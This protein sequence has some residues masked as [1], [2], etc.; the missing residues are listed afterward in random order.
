M[1][2]KSENCYSAELQVIKMNDF[3]EAQVKI[4]NVTEVIKATV[5]K[6]TRKEARALLREARKL[7][8]EVRVAADQAGLTEIQI[9]NV[10]NAGS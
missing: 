2:R 4:K 8:K 6:P 7:M 5:E 3:E 9:E 10:L 1:L